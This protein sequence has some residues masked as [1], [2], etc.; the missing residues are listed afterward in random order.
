MCE[1]LQ[2]LYCMQ[3][4]DGDQVE[5]FYNSERGQTDTLFQTF[6]SRFLDYNMPPRKGFFYR[7]GQPDVEVIEEEQGVPLKLRVKVADQAA[8]ASASSAVSLFED[9]DEESAGA[10]AT[11]GEGSG[12]YV[13]EHDEV[14]DL[15]TKVCPH[16]HS[17]LP[18]RDMLKSKTHHVFFLGGTGAGKTTYLVAMLQQL[19]HTLSRGLH[20]ATVSFGA[21]SD[22][23]YRVLC[24]QY[25]TKGVLDATQLKKQIGGGIFPIVMDI[26][27]SASPNQ[28]AFVVLHDFPGEG[29]KEEE[30][31]AN[32]RELERAETV[33]VIGDVN[34]FYNIDRERTK[35]I[36]FFEGDFDSMFRSIRGSA[37]SSITASMVLCVL[38]KI[39]LIMSR[40]GE[41]PRAGYIAPKQVLQS[42][43]M[44]MHVGAVDMAT[45]DRVS[46]TVDENIRQVTSKPL[47]SHLRTVF[48]DQKEKP[49]CYKCF[50]VS[51]FTRTESGWSNI[52]DVSGTKH[53][54][55]EPMLFLLAS[56]GLVAQKAGVQNEAPVKK[57]LFSRL[58]GRRDER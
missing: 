4:F 42:G 1:K 40:E 13:G 39:D 12:E 41:A 2:C 48:D 52:H 38:L 47:T 28:R 19:E 25:G 20:L 17:R 14:R 7:K 54:V 27:S 23:Y 37:I 33:I 22:P 44:G 21:E 46:R 57:S 51:T 8:G 43:D 11:S 29:M 26:E 5:F 34:Q 35:D 50:G 30:Y 55:I 24:E 32:L 9:E 10:S 49:K 16:C 53:R 15:V 56:W 45:I 18:I 6:G 3:E 58:F 31:L 36:R